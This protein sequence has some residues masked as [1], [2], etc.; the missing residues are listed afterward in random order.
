MALNNTFT[1]N[2]YNA[3]Q[4]HNQINNSNQFYLSQTYHYPGVRVDSAAPAAP[5][6][7]QTIMRDFLSQ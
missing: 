6:L 1:A 4:I 7:T 5:P 3:T 2:N